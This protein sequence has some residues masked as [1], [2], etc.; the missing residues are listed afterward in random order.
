MRAHADIRARARAR[1]RSQQPNVTPNLRRPMRMCLMRI[2]KREG[3]IALSRIST[4]CHRMLDDISMGDGRKGKRVVDASYIRDIVFNMLFFIL[5][6]FH[7]HL[8]EKY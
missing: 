2:R 3:R 1:S 7:D 8:C 4:G 6:R 5:F